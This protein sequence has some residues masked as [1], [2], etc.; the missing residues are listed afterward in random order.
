MKTQKK[1]IKATE[2]VKKEVQTEE[3]GVELTDEKLSSVGAGFTENPTIEAFRRVP[4]G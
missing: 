2:E 3:E 1:K 4:A